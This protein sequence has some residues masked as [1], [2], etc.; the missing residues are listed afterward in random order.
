L[1]SL[2][3]LDLLMPEMDGF[4]LVDVLR[5]SPEYAALPVVVMT[6]KDLS[7]AERRLLRGSVARVLAKSPDGVSELLPAIH[8]RLRARAALSAV[9][10]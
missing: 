5:R 10:G 4:E 2:L 8:A 9:E 6:A 1:P 3:V 7:E